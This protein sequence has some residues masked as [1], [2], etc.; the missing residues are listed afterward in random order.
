MAATKL[1]AVDAVVV[2]TG[3]AGSI[4]CKSLAESGLKVV[5][6]ERGRLLDTQ[7]DF[8]M[9]YV[10]DEL[11][12]DRHSDILQNLS[13]ETITFR[14]RM[15]E[16]ALPMRELG[17]FKPGECVG[18]AAVHW[19]CH[20]KR[21]LP[22]DFE[23]KSQTLARYGAAQI[24]ADCTTQDWGISYDDLEPYYDQFEHLYGVG[25][26]A[27]NLNGVIEAGGNPFEGARSREFPNPAS[28]TTQIGQLFS[29]AVR[30]FGYSP[31]SNPT[32]AMTQAY[33]NPYKLM[34]GECVGGGFCGGHVCAQGAKANPLNTVVPALGRHDNFELR[35]LANVIK[36]NLD[37]TGKRAVGVTYIDARGREFEQPADLVV[38]SAYTFNNVRLLM[39][40]GIGKPYDPVSG[41]GTLGRNYSYQTHGKVQMFF[42]DRTFNP[43]MGGGGRGTAIDDF[44]GDNF[45]HA[46][47]EFIGGSYIA[48]QA[49][50]A[51]P[52]KSKQVPPGTPGWGAE[53]KKAAAHYYN[54]S[55]GLNLHGGCQSYRDCYLDLD[56]TYRD[57]NGLPL[58]R[59]TFDWHDNEK[60]M[61]SHIVEK[62]AEIAKAIGP[63][64]TG[65]HKLSAKYSIVPYQ[66]THNIGGAVMGDDPATSVVN[67]YLQSWDVNNVFV[68]GGSAFP[69]NSA[70]PPTAT[71][72]ALACWAA[73][74]IKENYLKKPGLLV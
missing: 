49:S 47:L 11:K 54:R 22:W 3:L 66:S 14:N 56:P 67:K 59:M 25:G 12:Y 27:G 4:M 18:G 16:L 51:A 6:F 72:G 73:D 43:F 20:A 45:D 7:H 46:G 23:A 33:T 57:A 34:L 58:L 41:T 68:V 39:L 63:A 17:S 70:N 15:S 1:K 50:G 62:S 61:I 24:A 37:S 21:F 71:I 31:H 60:K 53:W 52:I 8:A 69:Q 26:K 74:A 55:F 42:D 36:I 10:H 35:T 2:G 48:A 30:Q 40:S 13:R 38:L 29:D 28:K 5:G 64:K 65:S 44:N 9:P 19:G 32:A